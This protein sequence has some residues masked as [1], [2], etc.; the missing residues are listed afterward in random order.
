MHGSLLNPEIV[1]HDAKVVSKV[2]GQPL[3]GDVEDH[4][5]LNFGSFAVLKKNKIHVSS[6]EK[7]AWSA[8]LDHNFIFSYFFNQ[9]FDFVLGS[10]SLLEACILFMIP[11]TAL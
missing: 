1:L 8:I 5:T 11:F 4:I 6:T 3:P 9:N 7:S 2:G 10:G